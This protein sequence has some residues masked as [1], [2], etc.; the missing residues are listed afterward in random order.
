MPCHLYV[1]LVTGRQTTSKVDFVS[2]TWLLPVGKAPLSVN[3]PVPLCTNHVGFPARSLV[4]VG[5]VNVLFAPLCTISDS[6][7]K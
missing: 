6:I 2:I 3:V 7:V 1:E 4:G 5:R